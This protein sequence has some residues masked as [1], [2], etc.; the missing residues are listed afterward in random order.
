V[1]ERHDL[2]TVE[3][4]ARV[5]RALESVMKHPA[6]WLISPVGKLAYEL[7]KR[8]SNREQVAAAVEL[9]RAG[10]EQGL[11]RIRIRLN[12]RAGADL[13][14]SVEGV[15][16]RTTIVAEGTIEVEADYDV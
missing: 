14:A 10:K 4:R 2:T 7:S 12:E 13:G 3:G 11:R 5:V 16:L 9:I 1:D 6:A 8:G 15:P